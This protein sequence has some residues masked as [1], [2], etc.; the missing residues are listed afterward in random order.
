MFNVTCLVSGA[1]Y[2]LA[3]G[4]PLAAAAVAWATPA[5]LAAAAAAVGWA[6]PSVA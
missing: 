6:G 4:R 3:M 5:V 1:S 2:A